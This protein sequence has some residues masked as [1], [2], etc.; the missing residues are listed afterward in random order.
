MAI[1]VGSFASNQLATDAVAALRQAG[2]SNADIGLLSRDQ[3][4]TEQMKN[5]LT[6][7]KLE[8]G[9]GLG[10]AGGAVAGAGLGLAVAAGLLPP[11]GPTIAGGVLVAL[12][13]SAGG[14]AATGAI[15][16][17]LVGLGI[18]DDDAAHYE[19]EFR[20][21]RTLVTVNAGSRAAEAEKIL[22][23]RGAKLRGPA[24]SAV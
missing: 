10:A 16:G 9:A 4:W 8:Q 6:G 22:R 7:T 21:G 23:D 2:F 13:A 15:V 3:G 17:G 14:G 24:R 11:L 18:P 20:A 5:D 19:Q 1:V 12:L